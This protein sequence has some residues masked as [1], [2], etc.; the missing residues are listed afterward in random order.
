MRWIVYVGLFFVASFL[1]S[2]VLGKFLAL[3]NPL[4]ED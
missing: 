2:L 3:S 4:D 1:V